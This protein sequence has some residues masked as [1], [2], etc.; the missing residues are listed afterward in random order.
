LKKVLDIE[1]QKEYIK[2]ELN[3]DEIKKQRFTLN[4][5]ERRA[6]KLGST[7]YTSIARIFDLKEKDYELSKNKLF[8][9]LSKRIF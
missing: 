1:D 7:T 3:K 2:T 6:F 5:Q 9:E 8:V 4:V